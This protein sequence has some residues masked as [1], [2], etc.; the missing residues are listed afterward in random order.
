MVIRAENRPII[1]DALRTRI[2]EFLIARRNPGLAQSAENTVHMHDGT[3]QADEMTGASTNQ[4]EA[5]DTS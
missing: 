3:D 1:D 2:Q 4:G 5:M